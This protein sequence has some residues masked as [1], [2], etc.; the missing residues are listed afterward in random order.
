MSQEEHVRSILTSADVSQ[1]PV[2][3]RVGL[4]IEAR[5]VETAINKIREALGDSAENPRFVPGHCTLLLQL[6]I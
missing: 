1:L 4:V 6:W 2:R 3:D 5:D